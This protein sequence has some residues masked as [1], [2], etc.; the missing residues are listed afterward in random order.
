MNETAINTYYRYN[1]DTLLGNNN[2]KVTGTTTILTWASVAIRI[3]ALIK[4]IKPNFASYKG[5]INS[6]IMYLTDNL[7]NVVFDTF[8]RGKAGLKKMYSK[9]N[10]NYRIGFIVFMVLFFIM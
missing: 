1:G 6:N 8:L 10:D 5:F 3:N 7:S 9:Q 4:N 2:E